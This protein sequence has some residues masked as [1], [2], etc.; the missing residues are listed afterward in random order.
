MQVDRNNSPAVETPARVMTKE[1]MQQDFEYEMAQ[2]I[3]QSI[4]KSGL[5]SEEELN[6]LQT[7]NKTSFDPFFEELM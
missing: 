6:R 2:K 4:Y 3:S 7:L 5:I 1:K